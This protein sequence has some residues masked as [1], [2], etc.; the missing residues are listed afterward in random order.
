MIQR[1]TN[2]KNPSW[3]YYGGRADGPITVCDRWLY[4]EDG[5][6][7]LECF[8]ADMG[9]RPAGLTIE[10]KD[11]ELGY[12][13]ENCVWADHTAQMRNRRHWSPYGRG[14]Y[15]ING[16]FRAAIAVAGRTKHIGIFDTPEAARFAYQQVGALLA[17]TSLV[18]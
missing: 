2:P 7:G 16:K 11:N 14:V 10:R 6:T 12:S 17:E 13:P 1:C 8:V 4:G 3:K 18:A 15:A 9:L 5:K